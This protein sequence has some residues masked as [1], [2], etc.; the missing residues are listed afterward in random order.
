GCFWCEDNPQ[1][2]VGYFRVAV[3]IRP[4]SDGAYLMLGRALHG[5]GDREGAIAAFRH[6]VA[7]NPGHVVAK[8]LVWALAGGGELEEARAAWEKFLERDPPDHE[9]WY[10]YAQLCLFLGNEGAYRRNRTA[11]I[12]R[13]GDTS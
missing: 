3:A 11:L 13:F 10:G 9:S 6:S 5:A 4:T 1:E 8:E 12:A 7:L 2:A